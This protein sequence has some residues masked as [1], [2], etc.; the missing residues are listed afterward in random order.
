ML[1][2]RMPTSML[3]RPDADQVE[4]EWLELAR[5]TLAIA[6]A[7]KVSG[8]VDIDHKSL[9]TVMIRLS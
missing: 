1:V 7:D 6:A 3:R 5:H 4:P 9:L 2:K 8:L